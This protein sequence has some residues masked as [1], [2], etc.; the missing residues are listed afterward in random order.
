M[1]V[2]LFPRSSFYSK[3]FSLSPVFICHIW[4]YST[5][6]NPLLSPDSTHFVLSLSLSLQSVPSRISPLS[7]FCI[8]RPRACVYVLSLLSFFEP[9]SLSLLSPFSSSQLTFVRLSEAEGGAPRNGRTD[10][11]TRAL[12]RGEATASTDGAKIIDIHPKAG[13]DLGR[14]KVRIRLT[15]R[16]CP[17]AA[18][19][20]KGVTS[21]VEQTRFILRAPF[22]VLP[23]WR[24]L[25][26][27]RPPL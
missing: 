21:H 5:S 18:S 10:H 7:T 6:T 2:N 24:L 12:Q 23:F 20:K 14:D 4:G 15:V 8:P 27:I 16:I 25:M 13:R 1:C 9:F 19:G 17:E 3:L 22:V 11:G 26:S